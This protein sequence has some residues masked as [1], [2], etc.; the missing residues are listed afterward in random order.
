M[1]NSPFQQLCVLGLGY[2]GLPTASIFATNGIQVTGVDVNPFV[3]KTINEGNIHIEEPGLKTIVQAA[4]NSGK[5]RASEAVCEADAFIIAVPTPIKADKSA[6]MS[7]VRS[8]MRAILPYIRPGNLIVLESTSPP[9]TT[10]DLIVPMLAETGFTLGQDLFVAHCP[11]RVLPGRILTEL[12]ENHRVIGGVTPACA[13]KAASLYRLI[14]S[15]DI[16]LTDETTAE[17]VKVMENTY[18]DVNIALANELAIIAEKQQID[19]WRVIELANLHPRVNLHQPG[20]GVGGHCISVD[21]WFIVEQAPD[22]ARLIRLARETNDAMPAHVVGLILDALGDVG[23]AKVGVLGIAYKGN[24]DDIRESPA[25]EV[26]HLL[27]GRGIEVAVYDPHVREAEFDLSGIDD[28]FRDA[29]CIVLLTPHNEYRYLDPLEVG[30]LVRRRTL[31]DTRNFLKKEGWKAAGFQVVTLGNAS[32]ALP[33][34]GL[35]AS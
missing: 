33:T 32:R 27:R 17:M 26:V 24:V 10:R 2:I 29:D 31:V 13:E 35:P 22:E 28:A 4:I 12:L 5:L 20:P 1:T 16:H 11:E 30:K 8:A 34:S 23:Q 25:I 9:G 18:R 6:E 15:G 19:A 7:Y 3:V 14:V 21:P